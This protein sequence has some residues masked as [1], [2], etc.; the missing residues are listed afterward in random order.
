MRELQIWPGVAYPGGRER[1]NASLGE[2]KRS[3]TIDEVAKM[4]GRTAEQVMQEVESGAL[5]LVGP[6]FARTVPLVSLVAC[7]FPELLEKRGAD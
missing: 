2:I 6:D 7:Y 4:V 5:L 3:Y 1:L